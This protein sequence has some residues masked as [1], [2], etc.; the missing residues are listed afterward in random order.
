MNAEYWFFRAISWFVTNVRSMSAHFQKCF[1][2]GD[3][4]SIIKRFK[5]KHSFNKTIGNAVVCA[6]LQP[7]ASFKKHFFALNILIKF[8]YSRCRAKLVFILWPVKWCHLLAGTS[9]FFFL[10]W[11]CWIVYFPLLTC[12]TLLP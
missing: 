8:S 6:K 11:N 7:L 1:I 12:L 9:W 10:L 2:I 5:K 3:Q 4:P